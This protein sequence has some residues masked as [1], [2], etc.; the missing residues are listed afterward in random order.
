MQALGAGAGMHTPSLGSVPRGQGGAAALDA[1]G[2]RD[3][4]STTTF[5]GGRQQRLPSAIRSAATAPARTRG[6]TQR[7]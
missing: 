2:A 3:A 4:C 7:V 1:P 6:G 5:R